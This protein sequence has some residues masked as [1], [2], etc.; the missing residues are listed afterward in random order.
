[1]KL[2]ATVAWADQEKISKIYN[3]AFRLDNWLG[4][5]HHVDHI[6]PLIHPDVCGLHNEFN[7]QILTAK[8]NL[9]KSNKFSPEDFEISFHNIKEVDMKNFA[10]Q[11]PDDET[12]HGN[13][14]PPPVKPPVKP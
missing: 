13:E 1:M 5:K 12:G 11:L 10:E 7:L 8:E 3:L 9:S 2:N 4:C 14:P 6:V